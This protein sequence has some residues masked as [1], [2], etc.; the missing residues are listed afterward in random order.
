ASI[1]FDME[2]YYYKDLTIAIFKS[3]LEE[4]KDFQWAGIALQAYLKD[5]REDLLSLL[6]WAKHNS[7][8]I[9]VRLVK[10]AY[11]DYEIA[12]NR[13]KG[14]PVPVF[15]EKDKTDRNYE[16]LTRLLFEN[17]ESVYPA[18]ATHNIRSISNAIALAGDLDLDEG[19]F[20]FQSLYGMGEPIRRALKQRPV[21]VYCPVGELVP[22]MAYLVRGI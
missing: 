4:Y 18:I 8:R 9:T 22:G 6:S 12:V 17:A 10:G 15:L 11:W 1:T 3:I 2:H 14:W 5:T 7:R 20:E 19:H 16:E 21:R 13:Q